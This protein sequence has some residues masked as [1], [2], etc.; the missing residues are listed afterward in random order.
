MY[1][2]LQLFVIIMFNASVKETGTQEHTRVVTSMKDAE[3]GIR[4]SY[5]DPEYD[6]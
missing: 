6:S 1:L 3:L 4:K 5:S 2:Y